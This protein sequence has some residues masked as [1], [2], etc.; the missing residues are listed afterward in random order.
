MPSGWPDWVA[1]FAAAAWTATIGIAVAAAAALAVH[2]LLPKRPWH[3]IPALPEDLRLALRRPL[4]RVFAPVA[5]LLAV[6]GDFAPAAGALRHAALLLAILG[7]AWLLLNLAA[8][9]R[10]HIERRHPVDVV[11]NLAARTVQTQLR[12]LA[13]VVRVAVVVLAIA[14]ALMTFPGVRHV[15]AGLLASAGLAGLAVALAVKPVLSNIIAGLQIAFAQPIRI[16]DVV[17]VEGHW[18]RIE[19]IAATCVVVKVWDERRLLLPLTWFLEKPFENWTRRNAQMLGTVLLWVD[20]AA[21]VDVLRGKLI[22]LCREDPDWDGR[23]AE[24]QVVETSERAMQVR[25]LVSA[26]DAGRLWSLRCRIR[27]G[28][29]AFIAREHPYALARVRIHEPTGPR[30]AL[31]ALPE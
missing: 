11:D 2:L 31:A 3:G 30:S 28:L 9:A 6:A 20:P 24:V 25:A 18:G 19:E 29:L 26:A 4:L 12:V 7:L 13:Q 10:A 8:V 22:A 27:E 21:P 15:G 16:D 5:G 1:P 17:V 23:V 14:A